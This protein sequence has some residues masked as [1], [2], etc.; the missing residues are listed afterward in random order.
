MALHQTSGRRGLG[1]VL[2]ATTVMS[3]GL[4]PLALSVVVARLDPL[5][6]SW[7]RF[8]MASALLGLWLWGRG[9][10]PDLR[11]LS[12]SERGLLLVAVLGLGGNYVLYVIG[13]SMTTPANT[14]VLTQLSPLLLAAGGIVIFR[15]RI[16]AIQAAGFGLIALGLG[17]FFADQLAAFVDTAD[18]YLLGCLVLVTCSVVWTAYGL[19]QKQLLVRLPSQG[20]M[21][22]L[23]AGCAIGLTPLASPANLVGLDGREW[24]LLLFCALNTLV[25]YGAF[26]AS[27]EHLEASRVGAIIAL[28]PLATFALLVAAH[29]IW[30]GVLVPEH[31]SPVM[32]A[33]AGAVVLGSVMTSREPGE[34]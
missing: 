20:L 11:R 22:C 33:G 2:A 15:E 25:A 16:G 5:T 26:A 12:R 28:T 3:W 30:P 8:M 10:L 14:Q 34:R 21:L 13:L 29:R 1:A 27:L 32:L 24:G 7:F 9:Q 31:F 19:A 17:L 4:L 18:R 6:L 23:Y